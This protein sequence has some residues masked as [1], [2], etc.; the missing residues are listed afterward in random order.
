MTVFFDFG[1][2]NKIFKVSSPFFSAVNISR[3]QNGVFSLTLFWLLVLLKRPVPC[4]LPISSLRKHYRAWMIALNYPKDFWPSARLLLVAILASP[5]PR[6]ERTQ[7]RPASHRR[8]GPR[9]SVVLVRAAAGVVMSIAVIIVD[10]CN[11]EPS[12]AT[13]STKRRLVGYGRDRVAHNCCSS[14]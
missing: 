8:N 14:T 1:L 9:S 11:L 10:M 6:S 12:R 3:E 5:W 13:S 7:H 4:Q 2:T